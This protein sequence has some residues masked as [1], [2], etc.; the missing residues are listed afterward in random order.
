MLRPAS[1]H[2]AHRQVDQGVVLGVVHFAADPLHEGVL[3]LEQLPQSRLVLQ[4]ALCMRCLDDVRRNP[5]ADRPGAHKSHVIKHYGMNMVLQAG[6][7][8]LTGCRNP[9][10]FSATSKMFADLRH[11]RPVPMTDHC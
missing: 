10:L 6:L 9:L 7:H 11:V 3:P 1:L 5:P 2:D 4:L 8:A